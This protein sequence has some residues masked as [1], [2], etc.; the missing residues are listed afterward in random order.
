[1][2]FPLPKT[3]FWWALEGYL[4]KVAPQGKPLQTGSPRMVCWF[5]D[6][7]VFTANHVPGA[8]PSM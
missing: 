5:I 4:I 1:M 3:Y 2:L 6:E 7:G 8:A